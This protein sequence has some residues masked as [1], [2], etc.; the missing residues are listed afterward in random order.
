MG[1]LCVG[2]GRAH[3]MGVGDG[4]RVYVVFDLSRWVLLLRI[5]PSISD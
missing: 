5:Q 3:V 1:Q 4:L 2:V